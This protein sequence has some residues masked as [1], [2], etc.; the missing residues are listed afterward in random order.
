MAPFKASILFSTDLFLCIVHRP[1]VDTH[2]S[3][4]VEPRRDPHTIGKNDVRRGRITCLKDILDPCVLILNALRRNK[5]RLVL[6][7]AKYVRH[8]HY[9]YALPGTQLLFASKSI[10]IVDCNFYYNGKVLVLR[11]RDLISVT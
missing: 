9:L 5:T 2:P 7:Q 11:D 10:R 1:K 6:L 8:L 4:L 3:S